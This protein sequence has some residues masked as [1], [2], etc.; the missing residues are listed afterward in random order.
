MHSDSDFLHQKEEQLGANSNFYVL[1]EGEHHIRP[2]QKVI[3]FTAG[4]RNEFLATDV[5][6]NQT[7]ESL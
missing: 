1:Y 7:K 5:R 4:K 2:G 6:Y 3:E